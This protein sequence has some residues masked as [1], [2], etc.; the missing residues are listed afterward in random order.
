MRK[1]YLLISLIFLSLFIF[2]ACEMDY[3]VK[4]AYSGSPGELVVVA[5][6]QFWKNGLEDSINNVFCTAFPFLPQSEP[7]YTVFWYAPE[8]FESILRRHRNV[9][10]INVDDTVKTPSAKL[11]N[12]KW[13]K[14]Q[15]LIWMNGANIADI[16]HLLQERE[17]ALLQQLATKEMQRQMNVF[18]SLPNKEVDKRIAEKFHASIALPADYKLAVD[19]NDFLW[20]VSRSYRKLSGTRHDITK[21]IVMYKTPYN[22]DSAF[23]KTALLADRDQMMRMVPGPKEGS[24]VTLQSGIDPGQRI[25]RFKG[26]YSSEIRGLWRTTQSFLGGPFLSLSVL[27]EKRGQI[28][29]I[30]GFVCAP[31]FNKREYMREMEAIVYSLGIDA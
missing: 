16:Y 4:P 5:P 2:T 31:K 20:A 28:I 27:D 7:K 24:Y 18:A 9:L 13:A 10:Y 19:S 26:M 15:L 21:G 1:L 29:T 12:S 25:Q 14:D 23:T 22:S 11:Y 30:E 3:D 17:T 8:K 6:T